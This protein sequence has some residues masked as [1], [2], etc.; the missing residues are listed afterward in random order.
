MTIKIVLIAAVVLVAL[1]MLRGHGERHQALRRL[2]LAAFAAL[3]VASIIQPDWLT[4]LA[5]RLGVGRGA[6]LLLYALIVVFFS[7][8]ATRH[9]RD[10]RVDRQLTALARRLALLE[11]PPPRPAWVEPSAGPG[12]TASGGA[13]ASAGPGGTASGGAAASESARGSGPA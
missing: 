1:A 9:M 6:D 10:R 12:G 7:Y 2:G 4:W 11:A 3:A 13:A 5:L 8:V